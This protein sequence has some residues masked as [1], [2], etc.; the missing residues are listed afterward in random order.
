MRRVRMMM[1]IGLIAGSAAAC[2]PLESLGGMGD[3]FG[4]GNSLYGEV[5][6]VDTR[7][8]R[9]QVR[10][11]YGRDQT[12]RYDNRTRVVYQNREY[13]V[14]SL[15]RGDQV[16]M[17]LAYDRNNTAWADRIE[18]RS[19]A[20]RTDGRD[21]DDRD[22]GD[23]WGSRVQRLEGRV[24]AIDV[25]RGYFTVT[26]NQSRVLVYMPR[27]ARREDVRRFERLRRGE[28]VRVEVRS[29]GRGDQAEL[30]R[31]R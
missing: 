9:I 31:F 4:G 18:V 2:A 13:P 14:S 19:S 23:I 27:N 10:E 21:R 3:V 1:S 5:R 8:G 29:R 6:S 26:D 11:Q 12:V 16:Q 17:R 20:R 28:R 24:Q 7:R 15:E 25:R 30:V 22:R